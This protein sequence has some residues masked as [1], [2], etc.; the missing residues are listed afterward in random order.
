MLNEVELPPKMTP[1]CNAANS[2]AYGSC[3]P[4]N[5][6]FQTL[7][8][9][10]SLPSWFASPATSPGRGLSASL[11][12]SRLDMR[13]IASAMMAVTRASRGLQQAG[14]A[15]ALSRG[16]SVSPGRSRGHN[17]S[18]PMNGKSLPQTASRKSVQSAV[19]TQRGD[20]R[21]RVRQR[22]MLAPRAA[23]K[24]RP[25]SLLV[26]HPPKFRARDHLR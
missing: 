5:P 26:E 15:V 14:R 12:P 11:A 16:K 25:F 24:G 2:T 1:V 17:G 9:M 20:N 22:T 3:W 23:R 10:V 18:C 19:V 7:S 21:Q 6:R 8:L 4:S 13:A